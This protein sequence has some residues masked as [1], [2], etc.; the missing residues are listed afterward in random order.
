MPSTSKV[1]AVTDAA[2][3]RS[4]SLAGRPRVTSPAAAAAMFIVVLRS[5]KSRYSGF[6]N[7]AEPT[8][9]HRFHTA[10]RRAGSW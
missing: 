7:A 2:N 10:T 1:L 6:D 9:S 5:L 3:T 8:P 4:G